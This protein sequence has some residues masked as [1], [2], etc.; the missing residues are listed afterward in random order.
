MGTT[1][2]FWCMKPSANLDAAF[3]SK[4]TKNVRIA[5]LG[6]AADGAQVLSFFSE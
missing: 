2:L 3:I 4:V 1:L 6:N 5:I